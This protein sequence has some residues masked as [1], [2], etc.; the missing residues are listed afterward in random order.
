MPEI[1]TFRADTMQDAL[2]MVRREIGPD[3]LILHTRQVPR[4]G[5]LPWQKQRVETE[6]VAVKED[7]PGRPSASFE[8]RKPNTPAAAPERKPRQEQQSAEVDSRRSADSSAP[9]EPVIE[10]AVE[11]GELAPSDPIQRNAS[12][13]ADTSDNMAARIDALQQMVEDL[14][15]QMKSEPTDAASAAFATSSHADGWQ[16]ELNQLAEMELDPQWAQL[17]IEHV[18]QGVVEESTLTAEDRWSLI[19]R[20]ISDRVR[21]SG[22]ISVQPGE[23]KIVALVGPTGVGK[24]TTIAKLASNFRLRDNLRLGLITVDTYR[25]AAV[26]QLRTYAEIID[27]PMKVVTTPDE[28]PQAVAEL[29]DMDLILID[30][31]GR[32][33][34]DEL[35]IQELKTFLDRIPVDETHLV[36]SA[37]TSQR[38]LRLTVETFNVIQPQAAVLTK[39]DEAP[40]RGAIVTLSAQLGLPVSY[41]TTG[42]NVPQDIEPA[43]L[44]RAADLLFPSHPSAV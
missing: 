20:E 13:S 7:L 29:A 1:R 27:L 11:P 6:I 4:K 35:R 42:Q 8:V 34:Q 23:Q 25:I 18:R 2:A 41:F 39:L 15:R 28:M 3:A 33:P 17:L 43:R 10:R 32:S 21:C 9:V 30:T 19:C 44:D 22:P 24:T 31:A 26:E 38:N 16:T 37:T 5:L 36:L 40:E 14:F 12:P